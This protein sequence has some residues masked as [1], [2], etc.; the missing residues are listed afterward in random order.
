LRDE[1]V[2]FLADGGDPSKAIDNDDA[3]K[4]RVPMTAAFIA[5][6]PDFMTK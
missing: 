3:M 6:S 2:S 1:L 4:W 5:I